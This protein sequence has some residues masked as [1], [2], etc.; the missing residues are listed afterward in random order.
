MIT[1]KRKRENESKR[2][3]SYMPFDRDVSS[4]VLS[5]LSIFQLYDMEKLYGA[6]VSYYL[7]GQTIGDKIRSKY[8]I[9]CGDTRTMAVMNGV[10]YGWGYNIFGEID[11][12]TENSCITTPKIIMENVS[13]VACGSHY[14][15]ILTEDGTL[16]TRGCINL[17]EFNC[18]K[19]GHPNGITKIREGV[20]RVATGGCGGRGYTMILDSSEIRALCWEVCKRLLEERKE[21]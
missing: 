8:K 6:D 18:G 17:D 5:Y 15:M 10:L 9:I 14:T 19:T 21:S 1:R 20:S 13:Q 11:D 4:I 7:R 2:N 16:Y 3:S 12:A